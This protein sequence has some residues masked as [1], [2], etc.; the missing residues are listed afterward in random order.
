MRRLH[1]REDYPAS[2]HEALWTALR[3]NETI[4]CRAC[5]E[6]ITI[7][8]HE[9]QPLWRRAWPTIRCGKGCTLLEATFH[10]NLWPDV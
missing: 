2:D 3:A 1:G 7:D 6:A 5:G 9:G 8:D 10:V 4:T